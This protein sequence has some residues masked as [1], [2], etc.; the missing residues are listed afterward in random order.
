M[1]TKRKIDHLVYGVHHLEKAITDFEELL[2]VVPVFGGYHGTEGTKNALINLGDE[3][4]LELLAIDQNN[5]AITAP[6]WMGI[7]ELTSPKLIRWALKSNQLQKDSLYLESINKQMSTVKGGKRTTS[8]GHLL[9]WELTTPLATP[10]IELAPFLIDWKNTGNHPS[11]GLQEGCSIEGLLMGHPQPNTYSQLFESLEIPY[12]IEKK[13]EIS[14]KALIK[15]P[16][17]MVKI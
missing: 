4:Y 10:E 16:K 12:K 7:D 6:R 8:D 13:S 3:C 17:G 5:T 14:I 2:G 1:N 15:S 11:H 9:E